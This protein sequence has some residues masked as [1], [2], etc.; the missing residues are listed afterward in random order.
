MLLKRVDTDARDYLAER[1]IGISLAPIDVD[2]A[3][4]DIWH[5]AGFERRADDRADRGIP[6]LRAT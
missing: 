4:N 3:L 1:L 5:L 2:D 6:A